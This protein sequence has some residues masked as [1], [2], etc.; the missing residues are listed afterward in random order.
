MVTLSSNII[1]HGQYNLW[2]DQSGIQL[3]N[4]AMFPKATR[5]VSPHKKVGNIYIRFKSF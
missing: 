4:L 3:K 2:I 5:H 1:L